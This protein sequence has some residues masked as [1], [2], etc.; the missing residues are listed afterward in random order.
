MPDKKIS[1]FTAASVPLQYSDVIPVL[2]SG[3]DPNRKTTVGEV[4]AKAI[5]LEASDIPGDEYVNASLI[6]LTPDVHFLVY[7]D[8]GLGA[9]LGVD[10]SYSFDDTTGTITIP[11]DKYRIIIL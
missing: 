3:G 9:L 10:E 6:G 2:Q 7:T 5:K 8:N 4:K 1:Q 11:A